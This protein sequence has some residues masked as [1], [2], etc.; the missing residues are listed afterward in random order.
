MSDELYDQVIGYMEGTVHD[1]ARR[2]PAPRLVHVVDLRLFRYTERTAEQA[3]VQKLARHVSALRAARLLL[4]YGFVQE[5]G[6]LQRVLDETEQDVF[7]LAVGLGDPTDLHREFLDAFYQ[8]EFDA[9]TAMD[10]TQKRKMVPRRKIRAYIARHVSGVPGSNA[11][12]SFATEVYRTSDSFHS[13]YVHGASPHLMAMVGGNP[14]QFHMNGMSGMPDERSH[15]TMFWHYVLRSVLMFST[16]AYCFGD[17]EAGAKIRA[18]A[19]S[20]ERSR[21]TTG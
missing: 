14:P 20:F 18:Y 4:R 15:R 7:F 3:I 10:S 6:V 8:E 5:V 21:P 16:V 11:N 17:M 13:G 19:D 9:D 12:P 1:L 2:V